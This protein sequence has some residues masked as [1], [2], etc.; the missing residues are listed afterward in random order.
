MTRTYP[1]AFECPGC[2]RRRKLESRLRCMS[3]IVDAIAIPIGTREAKIGSGTRIE[4]EG[5][6]RVRRRFIR[7]ELQAH[8]NVRRA[9]GHLTKQRSRR[10]PVAQSL[11]A[12][13]KSGRAFASC[14]A[15]VS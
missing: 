10:A 15:P 6:I 7:E 12:I 9:R 11:R 1:T 3:E 13:P 14:K 2:L 5:L 4:Y 8:G